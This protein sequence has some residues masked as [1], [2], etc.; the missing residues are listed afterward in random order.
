MQETKNI[1]KPLARIS[2]SRYTAL[3]KCAYRV[4]LANSMPD[5]LLP[6]PPASHLGN[7]IHELIG[8]IVAKQILSSDEFERTWDQLIKREEQT[9]KDRGFAFYIPLSENVP[10][11]TI[12]KLQVK[13]L[14]NQRSLFQVQKHSS[15]VNFQCEKWLQSKDLLIGGYADLIIKIN[16]YTK[17]SDFKS[18]KILLDEGEINEEYEEQLKLYAFLHFETYGKYPDDVTLIDL[19]KNEYSIIFTSQECELLAEEAKKLLME[20]NRLVKAD[21]CKKLAKPDVHYCKTCL[22]RP[23]CDF[24]WQLPLFERDSIFR[25]IRGRLVSVK[26]F[27]NGS[28]NASVD[29][30][31]VGSLISQLSSEHLPFLS[32]VLGKEVA[33][34]NIKHNGTPGKYQAVKTTKVYEV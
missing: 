21:D 18:G 10:G 23:A 4:I 11:Y 7:V 19:D 20:I 3:K 26:Q 25:D 33:F 22:Y 31:E 13:E 29:S 6:Y 8:L 24:Y 5:P 30:G 9:L 12:K 27:R 15:N 14:I 17:L 2:P 16:E 28:I 1:L 32:G 34:Y